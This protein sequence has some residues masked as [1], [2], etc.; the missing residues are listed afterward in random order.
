[1]SHPKKLQSAVM[2]KDGIRASRRSDQNW[3]RNEILGLLSGRDRG[4]D[5]SRYP[6]HPAGVEV[7]SEAFDRSGA[8]PRRGQLPNRL[9]QGE[10]PMGS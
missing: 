7:I 3:I 6:R 9:I 1:V 4:V 8:T 5:L 10:D 2:G